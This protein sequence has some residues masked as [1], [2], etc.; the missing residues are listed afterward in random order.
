MFS[1]TL[2]LDRAR[3]EEERVDFLS[4]IFREARRLSNLVESVLRFSRADG[5]PAVTRLLPPE[6]Q[7]VTAEVDDTLRGFA[8]LAAASDV[9]VLSD[10]APHVEAMLEPGAV[11][12]V[13]LNLLDNAIKYGPRGQTVTVRLEAAD[14]VLRVV[15][16]DEGPGIPPSERQRVFE[17]FARIEHDARS[18]VA[19]TG[20]GLSVVRD[21][22]AAHAGRA[23]IEETPSGGARV[24]VELPATAPNGARGAV[25]P[26][27]AAIA[28]ASCSLGARPSPLV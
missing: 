25:R 11:R 2:L 17:A 16:E 27:T 5:M 21:I 14:R 19:G 8:P 24:V 1:E 10:V 22:A 7:D 13:L 28:G 12:Q 26:G 3:S 20:I 23:W 6:P 4:A 18:R 15:V 9:E